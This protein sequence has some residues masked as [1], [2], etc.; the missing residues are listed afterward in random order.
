M[1]C[2]WA[3]TKF[4][5]S[6]LVYL[7]QCR[8]IIMFGLG[9]ICLRWQE[10]M[11]SLCCNVAFLLSLTTQPPVQVINIEPFINHIEFV[12]YSVEK[13][14]DGQV[15]I[16]NGSAPFIM[17]PVEGY[18]YIE[19]SYNTKPAARRDRLAFLEFINNLHVNND[20]VSFSVNGD[21]ELVMRYAYL[22]E[23]DKKSFGF[24]IDA[25]Q[26]ALRLVIQTDGAQRF[27]N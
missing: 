25:W 14:D 20:V 5:S 11:P 21:S 24:F 6:G 1:D 3:Q 23:Y 26:S 13:S 9:S 16:A 2:F 17:L 8:P 22:G 18:L 15:Y 19:M 12:N 4:Y 10:L 27:L 7:S